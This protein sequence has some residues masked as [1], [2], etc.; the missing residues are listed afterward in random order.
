MISFISL[1][2]FFLSSGFFFSIC[3]SNRG[4]WV[5]ICVGRALIIFLFFAPFYVAT[6]SLRPLVKLPDLAP[7]LRLPIWNYYTSIILKH[8][9][10]TLLPP[11]MDEVCR[12][13]LLQ[14]C[15]VCVHRLPELGV[16]SNAHFCNGKTGDVAAS[17]QNIVACCPHHL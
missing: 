2:E 8:V 11:S 12:V 6:F 3:I 9:K 13:V 1:Y 16:I 4:N 10:G 7:F 14:K 5:I 17:V 15:A